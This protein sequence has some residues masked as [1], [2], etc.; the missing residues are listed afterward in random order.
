MSDLYLDS[1]F[2]KQSMDIN[3]YF[4]IKKW[5]DSSIGQSMVIQPLD[6]KRHKLL[7]LNQCKIGEGMLTLK[8]AHISF[9][10]LTSIVWRR[11]FVLPLE[12]I[13]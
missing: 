13:A 2:Y 11:L 6:K 7:N 8:M 9:V 12:L 5:H 4:K 3:K 1:S 10:A